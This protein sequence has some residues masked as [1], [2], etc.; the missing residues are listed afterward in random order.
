MD[1]LFCSVPDA[2]SII[3]VGRTKIYQLIGEKKLKAVKIGGRTL[4]DI[5][6]IRKM[7]EDLLKGGGDEFVG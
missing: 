7:A 3:G 2:G 4:V 6:S 1:P 5:V